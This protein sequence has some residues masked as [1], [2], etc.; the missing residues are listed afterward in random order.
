[1]CRDV[2]ETPAQ[3][4]IPR[5]SKSCPGVRGFQIFCFGGI[6]NTFPTFD[7][8][9]AGT[10]PVQG[11]SDLL[12]GVPGSFARGSVARKSTRCIERD[13]FPTFPVGSFN[14]TFAVE[15]VFPTFCFASVGGL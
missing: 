13:F 1:M 15:G 4:S 3:F 14:P 9:G 11:I 2:L 8:T 6:G 5:T 12:P 10:I 7:P